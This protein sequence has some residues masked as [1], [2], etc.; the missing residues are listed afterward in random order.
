MPS[1]HPGPDQNTDTP[2]TYFWGAVMES[3]GLD[4]QPATS[5]G[6][7][8]ERRQDGVSLPGHSTAAT[9][10]ATAASGPS[11]PLFSEVKNNVAQ[12]E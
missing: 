11:K 6:T 9:E 2:D 4:V 10:A 7:S 12:R 5:V 8:A 3:F 1:R